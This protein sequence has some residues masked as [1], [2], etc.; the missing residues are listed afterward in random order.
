[1]VCVCGGVGWPG[2][3][4]IVW[5][6]LVPSYYW[7][8]DLLSNCLGVRPRRRPRLEGEEGRRETYTD[9]ERDPKKAE[10]G[11]EKASG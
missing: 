11:W 5:N 7:P 10:W 4:R 1:M 8:S 2:T 3:L 6:S 9:R